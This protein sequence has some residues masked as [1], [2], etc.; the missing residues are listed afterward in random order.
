VNTTYYIETIDFQI[1]EK[2]FKHQYGGS[3]YNVALFLIFARNT[4]TVRTNL[5]NK[6][7]AQNAG[8]GISGLQNFL[9]ENASGPSIPVN[10]PSKPTLI[11]LNV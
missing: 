6:C 9:G 5:T 4:S 1:R 7:N 11:T 10:H 8:N 2:I 3:P